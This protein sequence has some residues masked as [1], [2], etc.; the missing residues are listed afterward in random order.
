LYVCICHAV[1]E[2]DLVQ[3]VARGA[4]DTQTV[5]VRCGAGTSCG[6]CA[7]RICDLLRELRNDTSLAAAAGF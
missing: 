7:D 5:A 3:Q 1:T 2:Q 6:S 4:R